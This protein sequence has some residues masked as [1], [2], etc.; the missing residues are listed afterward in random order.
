[1]TPVE[2]RDIVV[3]LLRGWLASKVVSVELAEHMGGATLSTAGDP[4]SIDTVIVNALLSDL[5][6]NIVQGLEE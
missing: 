2:K 4:S 3:E 6:S 5:A 1:M